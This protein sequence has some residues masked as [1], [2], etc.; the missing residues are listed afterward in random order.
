MA[1]LDHPM[2]ERGAVKIRGVEMIEVIEVILFTARGPL[3]CLAE[4]LTLRG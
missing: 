1:R 3:V 4:L 2:K